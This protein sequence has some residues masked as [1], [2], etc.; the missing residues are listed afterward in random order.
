MKF[1]SRRLQEFVPAGG[2]KEKIQ[3]NQGLHVYPPAGW[4]SNLA[5]SSSLWK[6]L[7]IL[8]RGCERSPRRLT[9]KT[10]GDVFL[11]TATE[12]R[13]RGRGGDGGR[14]GL[15][16]NAQTLF[17]SP[18]YYVEV[19]SVV[20]LSSG[21]TTEVDF[22]TGNP[23]NPE[24]SSFCHQELDRMVFLLRLLIAKGPLWCL[25]FG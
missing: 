11:T 22:D 20:S 1:S 23:G 14:V 4:R 16:N 24:F 19:L 10:R 5:Q 18:E 6:C 15:K 8:G 12:A 21:S 7:E 9:D 3:G 25:C 17:K 13:W 2:K